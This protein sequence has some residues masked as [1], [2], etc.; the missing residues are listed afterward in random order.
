[1]VFQCR[2]PEAT[3]ASAGATSG[4]LNIKPKE[5]DVAVFDEI[6]LAL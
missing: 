1:L 4:P 2:T 6:L 5:H 3:R